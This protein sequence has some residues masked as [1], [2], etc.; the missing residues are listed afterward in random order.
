[1]HYQ[2]VA[3]LSVLCATAAT[4]R[5][6]EGGRWDL[7]L[8]VRPRVA[9]SD[10]FRGGMFAA[11]LITL[12][13][14]LL[15]I[16]SSVRHLRGSG[17][18]W[19]ELAMVFTPAALHEEIA[20]RGYVFQKIRQW[21]RVVAILVT[22]LVFALLHLGNTGVSAPAVLNL[23][24]AGVLLA[25]AYERYRRLWFPIGIHFVWNVL[26]GPILGY[27]VSGYNAQSTL[28]RTVAAGPA[29]LTGGAFGIEGS[30]WMG[31]V[32]A[33][34]ICWLINELRIS[35]EEFRMKNRS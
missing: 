23:I 30:V 32:E 19:F 14:A 25:L 21:N 33:G 28:V 16:S 6:L 15:L 26:S 31:I 27:G 12:A 7:G 22:A 8:F 3:L 1:M 4:I 9:A 10:V 24:L 29:W 5:T 13:D 35:N 18:P 17:F 11:L 2:W 20:F 34:G